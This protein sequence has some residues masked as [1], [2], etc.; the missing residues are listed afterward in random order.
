MYDILNRFIPICE[1]QEKIE[2]AQKYEEIKQTLRKNLNNK[3]WDG[4]WYR[5]AITD[6]GDTIGG[7]DSKECKIDSLSQSWSVISGAGD[8]DKKFIAIES[9]ENYLVDTENKIIKLFDPPFDNGEIEPGYIKDYLPGI[10]EN[11]GQYTHAAIW[12]IIAEAMLGFGE[13]AVELAQ[14]VC[15]IN[16]SKTREDSKV[17]KLEPYIIPADVYSS[18]GLEGRGGWNWY[19]G[20]ASWYYR[21]IVEYILGFKIR[22]NFMEFEPC[23]PKYWKEFE[24]KYKYKTSSYLIKIKNKGRKNTGVTRVTLDGIEI[25]NKKVFLEDNGK[26]HNIEIFLQ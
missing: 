13:K 24:I 23:I 5:R 17:F 6:N 12:L 11:G 20:A 2:K 26:F 1:E 9:A 8:N 25:E 10:R 19:T 21:A 14:L 22:N 15:P 3:A 18:K 16:H 7:I 4:R